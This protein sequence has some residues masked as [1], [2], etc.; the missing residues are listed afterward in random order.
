MVNTD[1][2]LLTSTRQKIEEFIY[3][4]LLGKGEI[5]KIEHQFLKLKSLEKSRLFN[6]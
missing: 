3:Q 1:M 2:Q 6:K 4:I 5:L